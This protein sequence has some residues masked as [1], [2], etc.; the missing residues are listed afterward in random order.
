MNVVVTGAGGFVGRRLLAALADG[1]EVLGLDVG[2]A[3]EGLITVDLADREAT[4]DWARATAARLRADVLVHLAGR[5][6]TRE[7]ARDLGLFEDNVR[8][9]E[10][11]AEL[12]RILEPAR[13]VHYSTM[14]VYPARDGTFTEDSPPGAGGNRD[15][16][17]GLAKL[18]AE[19]LLD[20]TAQDL[21]TTVTHLRVAQVYGPGM[22]PDRVIPLM[23]SALKTSGVVSVGGGG[24][25]VI[26]FIH[27]DDLVAVTRLFVE[28]DVGPGIYNVGTHNVALGDLA[29]V[30]VEE[31]GD[32]RSG[33]EIADDG[34]RE[35][36]I[37]DTTKLEQTL[38]AHGTDPL[39]ES[40]ED[41]LRR[42]IADPELAGY[43]A[44]VTA[45]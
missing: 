36:F 24:A 31:L 22:R 35:R 34:P 32:E 2:P 16:L 39:G 18:C 40:S 4:G 21:A 38:R 23:I 25:R 17:Y 26:P 11:A 28:N 3:S 10:G 8:I 27:V 6:A 20:F 19:G 15:G 43:V 42:H 44:R 1:H 5:V 29:R 37:L 13:V 41:S 30:I 7:T 45:R 33:I 12:V 9:A 14:A